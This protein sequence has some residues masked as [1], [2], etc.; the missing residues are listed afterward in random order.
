MKLTK[1]C[2]NCGKIASLSNYFNAYI[3]NYC[4]HVE[5]LPRYENAQCT[6]CENYKEKSMQQI[7]LKN[8]TWIEFQEGCRYHFIIPASKEHK[9]NRD[10]SSFTNHKGFTCA[11]CYCKR[12]KKS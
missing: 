7:E 9:C 2:N 5:D 4:N 12:I 10:E 1:L 11:E 6:N 8:E 3:C